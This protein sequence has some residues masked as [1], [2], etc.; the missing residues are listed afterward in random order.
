MRG[1]ALD[2]DGR[3]RAA[4]HAAAVGRWRQRFLQKRLEG[5]V[6]EPRPA[7]AAPLEATVREYFAITDEA[8]TPFLWT[9][10][11]DEIL[12]K[13]AK[14][15]QRSSNPGTPAGRRCARTRRPGRARACANLRCP[16]EE[17]EPA[18]PSTSHKRR[19]V[20]P[21]PG[22]VPTILSSRKL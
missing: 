7:R 3:A 17:D 13:V 21:S 22:L 1:G 11:A 14:F 19:S 15:C 9:K 10:T 8:P 12:A 5:L 6:E 4:D 20:N 18:E 16:K 2:G